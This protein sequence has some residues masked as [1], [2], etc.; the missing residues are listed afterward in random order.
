MAKVFLDENE[1]YSVIGNSDVFGGIGSETLKIAGSPTVT[2]QSTVERIEFADTLD[3]YTFRISGNVVTVR[4]G[5]NTVATIAVPAPA[6]G[7]ELAFADGS[8]ALTI[9]G[10]NQATLGGWA[11]PTTPGP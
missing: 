4:A 11:V 6:A 10:L 5:G 9:T 7:Q 2:V 3:T 1:T 8:A